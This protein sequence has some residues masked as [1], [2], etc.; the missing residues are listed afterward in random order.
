MIVARRGRLLRQLGACLGQFGRDGGQLFGLRPGRLLG[1]AHL[2]ALLANRFQ[3][4]VE[5][6]VARRA[7]ELGDLGADRLLRF[8][9]FGPFPLGLLQEAYE[10]F[11]ALGRC[12]GVLPDEFL[13]ARESRTVLLELCHLPCK[14]AFAS[15]S[16][17]HP[18]LFPLGEF[19]QLFSQL[20]EDVG[21]ELLK[22]GLVGADVGHSA[23]HRVAAGKMFQRLA[24]HETLLG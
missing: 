7:G 14:F 1:V 23:S 21:E 4:L 22:L 11:G 18:L 20:V 15:L 5:L 16:F 13:L 17:Q 12:L 24:R 19:R 3:H 8:A 2:R 10:V 6:I 9:H